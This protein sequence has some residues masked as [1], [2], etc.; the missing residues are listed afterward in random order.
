MELSP[1]IWRNWFRNVQHRR[2]GWLRS[3]LLVT[4]EKTVDIKIFLVV[5]FH[6]VLL[7]FKAK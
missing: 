3:Y 6:I 2:I 7:R 1:G 4:L 5:F